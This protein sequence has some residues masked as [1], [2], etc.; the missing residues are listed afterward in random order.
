M[1]RY[2]RLSHAY[3]SAEVGLVD[4]SVAAEHEKGNKRATCLEGHTA[5]SESGE[6]SN[7]L[8]ER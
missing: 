2:A 4:P 6:I 3:L 7:V 8:P 1:M 5:A